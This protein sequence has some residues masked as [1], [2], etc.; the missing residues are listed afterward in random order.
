MNNINHN[1]NHSAA[2]VLAEAILQLY[3]H[4]KLAIGPAI[5]T[6]FYYDIDFGDT[7]ISTHDFKQ[8]KKVMQKII[9]A[10]KPFTTHLKSRQE[11]L[12]FY[13]N[14]PYKTEII[15]RLEQEKLQVVYTGDDF[16]D[17]C[18]GG[19]VAHT[20]MIG[21]FDLL[22]LSAVYW[23]GDAN[24][25]TLTRIYGVG[26]ESQA[27]LK[28]YQQ[29]LEN[30]KKFDHRKLGSQLC[31]FDFDPL[32][33]AG[34]PLWLENGAIV[35]KLIKDF[36]NQ[37]QIAHGVDLV[38]TP[39]LGTKQLYQ[40]SGHWA[41][42][43]DNMF[44]TLQL[45]NQEYVLRPMTC[46]HHIVLFQKQL[47]SYRDLPKIYGENAILHRFE[48]SGA[49]LGLERVRAME[50]IDTHAF[51][52]PEQIETVIMRCYSM[53]KTAMAGF[54]IEFYRV[55]LSLHDPNN[56]QKFFHDPQFWSN[57]E[58]QLKNILDKIGINYVPM[59][60]EAAFYGP[61]ID[62]QI[63]TI[64]NKIITIGTIQLDCLLPQKFQIK[65]IDHNG[66]E[67]TPIIIH[68]GIIGTLERFI[69]FLLE[70]YKGVLPFW[71]VPEQAL[72]IPI[73]EQ[74]QA[75]AEQLMNQLQAANLRVSIDQRQERLGK[76][77]RDAQIQKIPYQIIIGDHEIAN[78]D[79]ITYRTYGDDKS[80]Y[81]L[82]DQFIQTLQALNQTP[83][84]K[85]D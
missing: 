76:K 9:N 42:Y 18:K 65:Y 50:L 27:Q 4:A 54:G 15:S 29:I 63:K 71:L 6:G 58:S 37:I 30:Q 47:W 70:H 72:I 46:P 78:P 75:Q 3:P 52:T 73:S 83:K 80:H 57:T 40:T 24:N 21:A 64:M 62:F 14:N 85:L 74:H 49:L 43:R 31:I 56:Q 69:S 79:H 48:H 35:H 38:N 81:V 13:H 26:F 33:G 25:P 39:I 2:H 28:E 51:I 16:F 53:I 7:V 8:I 34:L 1:L 19:H 44:P 68:L 23:R 77:I 22:K 36:V 55:D 59:I 17:L 84:H 11:L 60:G 41:H 67:Q 12:A 82:L 61:K 10:K 66:Q 45:E 20:G 5:E 32:I